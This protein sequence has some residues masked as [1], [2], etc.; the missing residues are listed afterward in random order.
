MLTPEEAAAA[1]AKALEARTEAVT[2]LAQA[3]ISLDEARTR[4]A[5]ELR[6][7]KERTEAAVKEADKEARAAWRDALKAGWSAT[8]LAK[9]GIPAP[10]TKKRS[11]RRHEKAEQFS[12]EAAASMSDGQHNDSSE[13]FQP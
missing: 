11:T 5:Q 1:A 6:E 10:R 2:R 4:A 12:S 9:I 3:R 8:E 13:G 7:V